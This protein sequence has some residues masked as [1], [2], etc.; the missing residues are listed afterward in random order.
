MNKPVIEINAF[1]GAIE[2]IFYSL[3]SAS[4]ELNISTTKLNNLILFGLLYNRKYY[5]FFYKED[6]PNKCGEFNFSY[7]EQYNPYNNEIINQFKTITEAAKE[8]NYSRNVI[9]K[10]IHTGE[11]DKYGYCWRKL[12]KRCN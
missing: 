4:I 11:P 10:C 9:S 5:T 12:N 6:N 8:L 7:I 2:R 1:N 3:K